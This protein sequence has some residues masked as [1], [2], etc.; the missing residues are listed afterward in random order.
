MLLMIFW[1][2]KKK[3]DTYSVLT[4]KI[5]KNYFNVVVVKAQA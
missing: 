5:E 4:L 2:L 3:I 1:N